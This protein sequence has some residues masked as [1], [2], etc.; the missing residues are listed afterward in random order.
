VVRER[1]LVNMPFEIIHPP[2]LISRHCAGP[3]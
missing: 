3:S 1:T 2:S